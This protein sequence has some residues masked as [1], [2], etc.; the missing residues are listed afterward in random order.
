M[1][2]PSGSER[3]P[4]H[5]LG[6]GLELEKAVGCSR[7][8]GVSWAGSPTPAAA[9]SPHPQPGCTPKPKLSGTRLCSPRLPT[10]A[11]PGWPPLHINTLTT[12]RERVPVWLRLKKKRKE[13]EKSFH[14]GSARGRGRQQAGE[15]G[16]VPGSPS[17][18]PAPLSRGL[19]I[20][21]PEERSPRPG[22]RGRPRA[23]AQPCPPGA[24]SPDPV[25]TAPASLGP[26]GSE[27]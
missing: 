11:S 22:V 10:Q 7:Q 15:A 17:G 5:W 21:K 18:Q 23:L 2:D 26:G 24:R 14:V 19:C 1:R 16:G 27:A 4:W 6:A 8:P 20:G 3:S 13:N 25:L 12:L 9:H